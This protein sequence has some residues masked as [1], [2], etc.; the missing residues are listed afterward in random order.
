MNFEKYIDEIC[1]LIEINIER[2]TPKSWPKN[3]YYSMSTENLF[4]LT[5]EEY[6]R[7]FEIVEEISM[8]LNLEDKF[9]KKFLFDKLVTEV[10][11]KSYNYSST[12]SE[13]KSNLKDRFQEFE[14]IL[15]EELNDWIY[16]IP[17][18][19]IVVE[20]KIDF[21]EISFYPF[22]LFKQEFLDYLINV[23]KMSTDDW[24]YKIHYD[25]LDELKSFCFAKLTVNG[26][27][28]TSRDKALSKVN[29]FLSIVSFYKPLNYYGFGI[30]GEVLPLSSEIVIYSR[31][32][33]TFNILQKRT[34]RG[35][36]FNLSESL[37]HMK[38]YHLDYLISLTNKINISYV[39]KCLL[40]S[41][42]WYYESVKIEVDFDKSTTE[43]TLASKDYY[44]HYSYF[45][46]GIKLI[47]LV[48]ALESLLI[49]ERHPVSKKILRRR[50]NFVMNYKNEEFHDY[51][52]DFNEIYKLRN[53][54]AHSNKLCN[55]IKFNIQKNTKLL[56]IFIY[57]FIELKLDYGGGFDNLD[58]KK[59]LERV[60]SNIAYKVL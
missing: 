8:D 16:F 5:F 48:S 59:D 35:Y 34:V 49:F 1:Q 3:I 25:E 30:M 58:S 39:E 14:D 20:D 28:E 24:E 19:G 44:E 10:I 53:D 15:N 32:L 41:L 2:L 40:N 22:N 36:S 51:S 4:K 18:S 42:Q 7:L 33:D 27:K 17:I 11:I 52:D 23:K 47:N 54:I 6:Q 45:K 9:P 55:L 29:E 37:E 38:K 26:T 60:Y 50:F 57:K 21:G 12:T 46:L 31:N 56:N 43:T 13:I